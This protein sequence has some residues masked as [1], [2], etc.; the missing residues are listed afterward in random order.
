MD[1]DLHFTGTYTIARLAGFTQ[2]QA[3]KIAYSSQ[4]VDDAIQS[5]HLLFLNHASLELTTTAHRMLDYRNFKELANHHVWIPFHFLPANNFDKNIKNVPEMVQRLTCQPNSKIAEDLKNLAFVN[6]DESYG[7]HLLGSVSHTYLDTWSHQNFVGINHQINEVKNILDFHC[8]IDSNKIKKIK[9]YYKR[10]ILIELRDKILSYFIDHIAPLGHGPALGYPDQPYLKWKY[11]NWD[12]IT[13]ERDNPK[14]FMDSLKELY[15]F[16]CKYR[17]NNQ[18]MKPEDEKAL[19][20]LLSNCD[21]DEGHNRYLIW[22][23][24]IANGKFSFGKEDCSY[25][26]DGNQSW[27]YKSL[28]ILKHDNFEPSKMINCSYPDN[29]RKS[30]WLNLQVALAVHKSNVIYRILP[31]YNIIST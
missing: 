16:F 2:E 3:H 5:G 31:K 6:R 10:T 18:R 4:Y 17:G 13:I 14:I 15:S 28:K 7:L 25:D 22:K 21:L 9:K 30:D 27:I 8:N 29:F 11:I 26:L 24:E 19:I 23:D 12:N 1:I 20:D